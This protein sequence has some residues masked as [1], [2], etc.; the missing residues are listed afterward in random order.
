VSGS[1][2]GGD[3]SADRVASARSEGA[4]SHDVE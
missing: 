1:S 4:A 2:T 3:G